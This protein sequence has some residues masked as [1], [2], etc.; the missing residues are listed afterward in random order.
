MHIILVVQRGSNQF[1]HFLFSL[2]GNEMTITKKKN[3]KFTKG[4][5]P[6]C[7]FSKTTSLRGEFQK[8]MLKDF[9][10]FKICDVVRHFRESMKRKMKIFQGENF[11]PLKIKR[12]E[13]S[14]FGAWGAHLPNFYYI[15]FLR[16]KNS[17]IIILKRNVLVILIKSI[18]SLNKYKGATCLYNNVW[19]NFYYKFRNARMNEIKKK[20]IS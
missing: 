9:S 18:N 11:F 10:D 15:K 4:W 13:I 3:L 20:Y 6:F 17:F 8:R 2:R 1:I 12:V 5:L 14:F 19:R 7:A 16:K